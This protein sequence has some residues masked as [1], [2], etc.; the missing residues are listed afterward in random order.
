MSGI[1]KASSVPVIWLTYREGVTP[2]RGYWDDAILESL[3]SRR[4]W[5][6]SCAFTLTHVENCGEVCPD[7]GAIVVL[8]ARHHA[9][10]EYVDRLN[11]DMARLPWVILM[12]I[13]DEESAF[14]VH[15]VQHPNI[16]IWQM[17]ARP[18]NSLVHTRLL[19][20][21]TPHIR[22]LDN[23]PCPDKDYPAFFA[24]QITHERR[25]ACTKAMENFPCRVVGTQGFTQGLP[26]DEYVRELAR[27]KIA[28]CPSGPQAPDSFRFSEA[29]E[30]GCVP[31]ADAHAPVPYPDGYWQSVLGDHLPFPVIEDWATLPEVVKRELADWPNNVNRCGAFWMQ[32][33]R[34]LAYRLERD[35]RE[36]SGCQ[37]EPLYL[38]DQIAID[39]HTGRTTDVTAAVA[40]VRSHYPLAE[41]A[42]CF[43][44]DVEPE[45]VRRLIWKC[46][47]E[48]R[49][50][51]PILEES[52]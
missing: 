6:P 35:I 42:L 49:N 22:L 18:D 43:D 40:S 7:D 2:N 36:L 15:L 10:A 31:I 27:A 14:P 20:G 34:D 30:A 9:T 41:I 5:R 23:Q 4:M 32:Y 51:L 3:F 48:W 26:P 25:R 19:N 24:G 13:G 33:K 11:A 8:P 17:M 50:V 21:W 52:E 45:Q 12:L 28:P 47:R 46:Q 37:L 16:R 1:G 39:I 44:P 38:D 29:L